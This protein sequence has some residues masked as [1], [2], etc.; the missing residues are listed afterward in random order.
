MKYP[1]RKSPRKS[2][3]DYRHPGG[4]FVTICTHMRLPLLGQISQG[5]MLLNAAGEIADAH[6]QQ[7][8]A[9]RSNI[10]I[11]VFVVMP[12][13]IHGLLWLSRDANDEAP[14]LSSVV[15]AY[16]AGVTREIRRLM[17]NETMIVWQK[18]FHDHIIRTQDALDRIRAY[19]IENPARWA[20]DKFFQ[21]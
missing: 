2:D 6:W 13:H 11:D 10:Q 21:E 9:H 3:Y 18:S 12:N 8:T 5:L 14:S 1:V 7:I 16:K 15:G 17:Q 20:E 4:Y 19:V